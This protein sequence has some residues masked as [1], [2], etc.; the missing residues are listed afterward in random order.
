MGDG[1][2]SFITLG[3]FR[4]IRIF[5][6]GE[7]RKQGA[8]TVSALSTTINALLSCGGI[9]ETGSLRK[10]QLK[11]AGKVVA[12]LDLYDLLL[13]G[14][15]SADQSLQPGD[16]IFVPSVDKQVTISGAVRRPAKYEILGGETLSEVIDLAAGPSDRSVLDFIRLER[17]N[18]KFQ[19]EVKNLNFAG[20][21]DFE[22]RKGD[23]LSLSFSSADIKNVVTLL[24]PVEKVG[25]YQWKNGLSLGDLIRGPNDLSP[26]A[27]LNYGLIRRKSASG[28]IRCLAFVPSDLFSNSEK[29]EVSL[30]LHDVVFFFNR[31]YRIDALNSLLSELRGQSKAG[32]NTKLVRVSGSV[33]FPGEYPLTEDMKLPD[34]IRAAGGLKDSAYL[35]D[36]E[37]T[38]IG[39]SKDQKAFVEHVRLNKSQLSENN[40]SMPFFLRPYDSLAIKPIPLWKEGETVEILG[41]VNFPGTYSMK[42]G[43]TLFEVIERAGGVT[44]RAFPSGAVFSR[45]NLRLKEEEQRDRLIAQLESDLAN[46]TLSATDSEEVSQSQ[47]AAGAMLVRLRNTQPQGRLV[48]DLSKILDDGE[49]SELR[50][51]AGDKL[52]IPEIPYAVSVSGEVQ[53][54]T[55]HLYESKLGLTDYLERSGGFTPNADEDRTFVVKANGAVMA[56]GG[57]AWF[58]KG[59]RAHSIEAGDNIVV[60]IDVKQTRFLENLSYSTQ[61]IYQL[62]VAAAAVNSF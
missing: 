21:S 39:L 3:A 4:S 5:L 18:E 7:V 17:L 35:L 37:I 2:Q 48:I 46:V 55:S 34:L 27:D 56:K 8:Y 10:I 49:K 14:D 57:N 13:N 32:E 33:H 23:L 16:V 54:P 44:D 41:E 12:T 43:E 58:G 19:P 62:A 25:D 60:P 20:D 11:R 6:L 59:I 26:S 29:K 42:A 47:A 53:F 15:T 1:V 50:I 61:I 45:E 31:G 30:Q 24:G 38:R 9:K 51:K 36:A 28:E 52:M 40:L 22:I